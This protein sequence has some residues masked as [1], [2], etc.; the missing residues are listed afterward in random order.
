MGPHPLPSSHCGHLVQGACCSVLL[1]ERELLVMHSCLCTLTCQ[2]PLHGLRKCSNCGCH[3]L[4]TRAN[5][6]AHDLTAYE[7]EIA[8]LQE[9]ASMLHSLSLYWQR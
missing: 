5:E 8:I 6:I 7:R 2:Q 4:C 3:N 1:E 9:I